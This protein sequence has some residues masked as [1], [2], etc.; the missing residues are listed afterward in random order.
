MNRLGLLLLLM[1]LWLST[2]DLSLEKAKRMDGFL[3]R[4]AQ[5]RG[6]EALFLKKVVFSEHDLN[7][8]LN[9]VYIKKYTPE[10]TLIHINLEDKNEIGGNCKI[11]LLG[12]AYEQ[13]PNFLRDIDVSFV[14]IV[15]CTSNR[16]R[17]LFR[18]LV[19]NGTAY[20]PEVIDEF[21]QTAQINVKVKK[22]LFDWFTLLPG[23]KQIAIEEDKIV[24]F[25]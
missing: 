4:I 6:G 21:F 13:V 3:N 1:P 2:Q 18:K 20:N 8:Y 12:K 9:L 11:K 23:L 15:D 10:V 7:S 24:C 19:I 25:Y 16:M 5:R 22:S 14:G 17:V